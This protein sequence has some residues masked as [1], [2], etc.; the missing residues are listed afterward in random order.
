MSRAMQ[1]FSVSPRLRGESRGDCQR[2]GARAARIPLLLHL[3]LAS[4][5]CSAG[6][7]RAA[8]PGEQRF[9]W[10][11]ANAQLASAQTAV[12]YK[13][14][15]QSYLRLVDADVR[16]GPLFFNLGA[17]LLKAGEYDGAS[18]A[19]LRAERYMGTN[20]GIEHDLILALARGKST[21][22]V[23]LPWYRPLLFWHYELPAAT[24]ISIAVLA[25]A[26]CWAALILRQFGARNACRQ[27]LQ[28]CL[29]VFGIFGTS[30]ASSWWQEHR[31][32]AVGI[33]LQTQGSAS[34]VA[35][36]SK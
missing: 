18:S 21:E 34:N 33:V 15:A 13:A 10:A 20:P 36:P 19:L 7:A 30:G 3:L 6:V 9:M 11:A 16:N 28:L 29:V 24:R 4:L 17:A 22:D 12:E 1:D 31:D 8:D 32:D 23:N 35:K 14:A 25:F 5:L 27:I 26:L 2:E